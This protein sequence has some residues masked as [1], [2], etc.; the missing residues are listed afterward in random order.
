MAKDFKSLKIWQKAYE[1]VLEVYKAAASFPPEEKYGL[2]SQLKNSANSVAAN[3]AE[4]SGRFHTKDKARTLYQARGEL[5]ETRSHLL[6]AKG[7]GFLP[8]EKA[9]SFDR[10]YNSLGKGINSF[11]KQ[12]Y[13]SLD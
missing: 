3:V 9:D 7:L 2:T 11:I 1:L 12:L 6:I 5:E 10:E 13:K 8:E 4:A